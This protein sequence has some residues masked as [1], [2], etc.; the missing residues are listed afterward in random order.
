MSEW[1]GGYEGLINGCEKDISGM[2]RGLRKWIG[3]CESR[4]CGMK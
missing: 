3:G 1:V 2:D 4:K